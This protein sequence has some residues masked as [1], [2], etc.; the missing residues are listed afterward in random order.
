MLREGDDS[1]GACLGDGQIHDDKHRHQ[2][3]GQEHRVLGDAL[4]REVEG[5]HGRY[6]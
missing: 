5:E 2:P 1:E 6:E 3:G 4:E